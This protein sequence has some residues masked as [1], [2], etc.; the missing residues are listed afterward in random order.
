[1]TR[2]FHPEK[3]RKAASPR[4][5][6]QTLVQ[7]RTHSAAALRGYSGCGDGPMM[8]AELRGS[9]PTGSSTQLLIESVSR[10]AIISVSALKASPD[11]VPGRSLSM[12][13]REPL[14]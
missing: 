10:L 14:R 12:A 3:H 8:H 9:G 4:V 1:M 5:T 2:V 6:P 13:V 11:L 7:Q